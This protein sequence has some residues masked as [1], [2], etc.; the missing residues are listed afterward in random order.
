MMTRTLLAA[1]LLAAAAPAAAVAWQQDADAALGD[2]VRN[3]IDVQTIYPNPNYA[4]IPLPGSNGRRTSDAMIRY[5]TGKL[6][7]LL[8]TNGKTEV[9]GQ[10]GATEAATKDVILLNTGDK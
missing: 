1:A 10:G 8:R 3:N 2:T 5:E 6:K 7:P 4:G 9:G